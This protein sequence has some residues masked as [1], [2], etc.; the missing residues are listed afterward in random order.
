MSRT[1]NTPEYNLE[2][3]SQEWDHSEV[4]NQSYRDQVQVKSRLLYTRLNLVID[5][6]EKIQD[7]VRELEQLREEQV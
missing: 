4:I 3:T 7:S 2:K 1:T 6:L 5:I